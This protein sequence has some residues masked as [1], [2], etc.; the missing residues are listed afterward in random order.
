MK[1]KKDWFKD[2]VIY[3][4]YPRSFMDGNGDGI[5]DLQGMIEKLD[6]LKELGVNAV[7][8]SPVYASPNVDNGYDISDYRKIMEEFGTME[9][10][11]AFRDGAHERGIAIIMDLVLNHSSDLHPWFVESRKSRTNQYSDYYIWRDPSEDGGAPNQWQSVFGGSAWEYV[12][13]RGQYYLHFFAKEQPD[14]NWENETAR[15]DIFDIIRFWNEKGVDGYRIDAISYLD[16]GLDGRADMSQLF[17]TTSCANLEG[18]HRYIQEMIQKTML[19]DHLVTIGEVNILSTE[20]TVKY[21]DSSREEFDMVIPFIPPIV[22]IETW[23]PQNLKTGITETYEATKENCWWARFF[24]NHDKPRQV[25]LY[26]NDKIYWKE[27][28]KM[29]ASFLHTLPGTPFIYQGEEI[30]MTNIHLPTIDDYDDID[31]KNY[32]KTRIEEGISPEEALFAAQ[33]ISRDNARTPMQW[34]DTPNGGFTSGTP[35]LAVN[36]NYSRINVKQQMEEEDSIFRFYQ[37]LIRLRKE[38]PVLVHGDF[39]MLSEDEGD[40][41]CYT[42]TLGKEVW[43]AIHNFSSEKQTFSNDLMEDDFEVILTNYGRSGTE[44]GCITLEPYET[45]VL[46]KLC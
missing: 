26:G 39:R 42:R 29:L 19:P 21:T 34:D 33:N 15:E 36:A 1:H 40:V 27:S 9:E 20:D 35:W 14:L 23:S 25:S 16:K 12:P 31:T 8:M 37:K 17:G 28:A 38:H 22:E 3:Q 45:F 13:E 24:S 46:K 4:I 10:W 41:I 11:E 7:W 18:T 43:L 5:G 2:L 32:Y 44:K 6:Y 30:G